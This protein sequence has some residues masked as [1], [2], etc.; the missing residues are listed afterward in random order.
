MNQFGNIISLYQQI[1]QNPAQ[2]LS[3]KYNLSQDIDMSNPDNII[4]HLLNT[5]QI[6]E[7]QLNQAR[8]NPII[9]MFMR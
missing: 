1:K 5:G 6:S 3:K 2:L 9:Q 4:Q 8:N 7:N